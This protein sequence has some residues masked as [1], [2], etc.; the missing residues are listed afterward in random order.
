MPTNFLE[1][2]GVLCYFN[3]QHKSAI[4]F[5]VSIERFIVEGSEI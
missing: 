5:S 1:S 3:H 4:I 2:K